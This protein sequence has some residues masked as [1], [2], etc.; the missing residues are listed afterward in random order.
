MAAGVF[1]STLAM[2][3]IFMLY[4]LA[5][6][7][8]EAKR[9]RRRVRRHHKG[10]IAF[11]TMSGQPTAGIAAGRVGQVASLTVDGETA[12]EDVSPVVLPI[13]VRRLAVKRAAR[14]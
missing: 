2:A 8:F 9:P 6:F 13:G 12:K 3:L 10:V 4:V 1:A 14:S 7:Y 11:R 5:N